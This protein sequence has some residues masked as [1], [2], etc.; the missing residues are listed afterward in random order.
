MRTTPTALA[1]ALLNEPAYPLAQGQDG[2][3]THRQLIELGCPRATIS[4]RCRPS[5]PWQ[6]VLPRV[7][8]LQTGPPTPQQR[9]RAALLYA[10]PNALLTGQA[11]LSLYAVRSAPHVAS[12]RTVDI[13]V[14]EPRRL[15]NT[16]YVRIHR[17]R[18]VPRALPIQG[19]P[20]VP[21]PRA[22]AD[23]VPSLRRESD[24]L[25][26]LAGVVQAGRCT[27]E[28]L[29]ASLR[30]AHLASSPHVAATLQA[31][32]AGVL[33]VAE[34]EAHRLLAGSGLPTPL[35]NPT[36]HTPSGAFLARPD[37][38]W[39]REGVALEIDS[40]E[41]HLGPASYRA[42]L[43][44]RLRMEGYGVGVVS[45]APRLVRECP[46]EVVAA[47]RAKLGVGRVRPVS[48]VV[49]DR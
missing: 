16:A 20:C 29:I 40:E 43:R 35:W 27:V 2:L 44:R 42:T 45:V 3:L 6:R 34:E 5:G 36:L 13:L 23:T 14:P 9:L 18:H 21:L 39:P 37:A 32:I 48:V 11:A 47:I 38:Y 25:A 46:G 41:F 33:S 12:L 31:L 1:H 24:V 10:S 28:Q 22:V 4:H 26:L 15:R 19:L 30:A 7:V 17:T 8:L 49:A